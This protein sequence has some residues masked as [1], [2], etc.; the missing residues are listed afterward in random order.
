MQTRFNTLQAVCAQLQ[1]STSAIKF[2]K[3]VV[4]FVC[5]FVSFIRVNRMQL[6]RVGAFI[7]FSYTT[8]SQTRNTDSF[9]Y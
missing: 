7:F 5:L 9:Y 4:C 6:H 8:A 2:V 3:I 1:Q